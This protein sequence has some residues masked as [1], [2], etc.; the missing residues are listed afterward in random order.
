[1][2]SCRNRRELTSISKVLLRQDNSEEIPGDGWD[3][4]VNDDPRGR[5]RWPSHSTCA[6]NSIIPVMLSLSLAPLRALIAAVLIHRSLQ[7]LE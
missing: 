4:N 3:S 2:A 5:N 1:M 7:N 6:I